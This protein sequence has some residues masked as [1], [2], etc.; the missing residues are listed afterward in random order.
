[1]DK[2]NAIRQLDRKKL[3]YRVHTYEATALSG[4][5]VAAQLGQPKERVY[6]TL[7][8]VGRSGQHYVFMVPV[9]VEL[10][11]K[12]AAT[13]V[14]EKSIAMLPQKE[15]LPLTGY[16]HGGCSPIGMKK[17]LPT[18]IDAS[19][20]Q[21]QTLF[22]SAGRLGMQLETTPQTLEAVIPL[23]YCDIAEEPV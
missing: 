10:D 18:V 15:L 2:T 6:K 13:A 5:E 8:T 12:K 17:Q 19:A 21:A 4:A 20:F 16:I 1:M 23:H 9:A 7:V 3:P 22:F 14:G 11:L